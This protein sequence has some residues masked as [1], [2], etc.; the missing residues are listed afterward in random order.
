[1]GQHEKG[2]A[3]RPRNLLKHTNELPRLGT[4]VLVSGV[5]IGERVDDHEFGSVLVDV[6]AEL[7]HDRRL[8][9]DAPLP[10]AEDRVRANAIVKAQAFAY[11]DVCHPV[12]L[13]NVIE[14]AVHFV[15]I[16][17]CAEK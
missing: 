10:A 16:V 13:A 12:N 5:G 9:D 3:P 6:R 7:L 15:G 4:V 11:L 1:M 8:L 14:A 17:F 2:A